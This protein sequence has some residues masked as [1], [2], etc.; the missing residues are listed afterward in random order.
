MR[1]GADEA[2]DLTTAP[3]V[4]K[5]DWYLVNALL[6]GTESESPTMAVPQ[7]D[8]EDNKVNRILVPFS[9]QNDDGQR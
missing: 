8:G 6:P 1:G 2:D 9:I 4:E 5:V 3:L 7:I